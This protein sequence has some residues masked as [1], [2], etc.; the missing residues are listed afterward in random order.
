MAIRLFL[1]RRINI[2]INEKTGIP[3]DSRFSIHNLN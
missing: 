1:Y 2:G 3:K